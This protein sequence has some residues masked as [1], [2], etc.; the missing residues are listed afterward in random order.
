[1]TPYEVHAM[2]SEG[3][4]VKDMLAERGTHEGCGECCSRF[5]PLS[6]RERIRLRLYRGKARPEPPDA[7]DLTCPFLTADKRCAVYEAR[8]SVCREYS[9]AEHV[10]DGALG[11][12]ARMAL[13]DAYEM[14]D[15][16]EV[17]A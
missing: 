15:M 1:M 12:A 3:A 9:C 7:I 11:I 14:T 10:R 6:A 17:V 13:G 5:L 8:P 2:L 4:K 16:R